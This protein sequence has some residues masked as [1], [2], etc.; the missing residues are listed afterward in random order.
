MKISVA[1]GSYIVWQQ[2]KLICSFETFR[3]WNLVIS[4]NATFHSQHF[5]EMAKYFLHSSGASI[6][7]YSTVQCNVLESW[8]NEYQGV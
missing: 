5:S 2:I 1:Y 6:L 7:L 4:I 3:S 8:T